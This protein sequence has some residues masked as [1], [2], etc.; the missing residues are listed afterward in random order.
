M[1]SRVWALSACLLA[2][3][4]AGVVAAPGDSI[5]AH[6]GRLV[7]TADGTRLN[8]Y[9][10][11]KGS[12]AVVFDQGWGDWSPAWAVVQPQV[13][14]FTRVC[15]YDRAGYGF[16]SA[17]PMPRTSVRVADELHAAL[18]DAGI[19]PPYIIVAAHFGSYNMRVFADRYM[20]EVAGIVLSDADDGDVEPARWQ[21]RDRSA[22]PVLVARMRACRVAIASGSTVPARCPKNFFRGLPEQT[23]SNALNAA[24]LRDIRTKTAPY[25]AAISEMESMPDDWAYLQQHVTSFGSRPIRVLTTWH[26]GRPPAKPAEVHRERISFERDSAQAQ[27]SWLRLSTNARQIFDYNEDK[28]YI[29]LDHPQIVVDA[30]RDVFLRGRLAAFILKR[31][32]APSTERSITPRSWL[33]TA[34][35]LP[36]LPFAGLSALQRIGAKW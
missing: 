19:S 26:F 12:P 29:Q 24:L 5:Y 25:D 34:C 8:I 13:A 4:Q 22:I 2:Q 18:R 11:G 27:A 16:S 15:A 17:G 23:F 21:T 20:S 35:V 30:I 6:P 10:M 7:L 31:G 14:T 3:A 28:Q 1:K 36:T 9:C 33:S 32:H